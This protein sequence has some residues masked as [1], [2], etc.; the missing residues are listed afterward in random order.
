MEINEADMIVS[1]SKLAKEVATLLGDAMELE[2]QPAESPFPDIEDRVR[3]LAPGLLKDL[4]LDEGN[5]VPEEA[6]SLVPAVSVDSEGVGVLILPADFQ[7]LVSLKMS[8]WRR[9][10]KKITDTD[11]NEYPMQGSKWPGIRGTPERPVVT[12]GF[13]HDG[14]RCLRLFSCTSS[15]QP[16]Y[17]IY[18]GI[19]EVSN[20]DSMEI[21][22]SL[23]FKLV[24]EIASEIKGA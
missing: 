10:V 2:C 12:A 6:K 20:S 17:L 24:R 13:N 14:K 15:S 23:Y 11:S 22:S 4:L 18:Q 1:I 5:V 3:I 19:P 8:D 16:E 9:P 21:P 7:R